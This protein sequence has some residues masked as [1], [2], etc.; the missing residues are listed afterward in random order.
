M[1]WGRECVG[2]SLCRVTSIGR[3]AWGPVAA[4]AVFFERVSSFISLSHHFRTRTPRSRARSH[5]PQARTQRASSAVHNASPCCAARALRRARLCVLVR[6]NRAG[7]HGRRRRGAFAQAL[8]SS[9]CTLHSVTRALT[10]ALRRP[11]RGLLLA[12][13]GTATLALAAS[14]SDEPRVR[15]GTAVRRAV[16]LGLTL[17]RQTS[18]VSFAA[19]A[20]V[21]PLLRLLDGETAHHLSI[22]AA[23]HGLVPRERRADPPSL[24]ARAPPPFACVFHAHARSP[25]AADDAVGPPFSKPAGPRCWL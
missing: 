15:C 7:H 2:P 19:S 4:L 24:Q 10:C 22:W 3:T 23:S 17:L 21:T 8:A 6:V 12:G 16:L 1:A 11:Q 13:V 9:H 20:V 18:D 5:T 25:D 14:T